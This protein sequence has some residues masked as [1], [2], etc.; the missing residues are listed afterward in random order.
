MKY[1][2][3]NKKIATARK[4]IKVMKQ[5]QKMWEEEATFS[6][7]SMKTCAN[8]HYPN[9]KKAYEYALQRVEHYKEKTKEIQEMIKKGYIE[10]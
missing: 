1:L 9:R 7:T 4:L 6:K 5:K 8:K 10:I 3:S 2:L